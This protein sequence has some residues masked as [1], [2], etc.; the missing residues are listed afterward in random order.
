MDPSIAKTRDSIRVRALGLC[1]LAAASACGESGD[2]P[3]KSVDPRPAILFG[4]TYATSPWPRDGFRLDSLPFDG[5]PAQLSDLAATMGELDGAPI[6]TS[7]F[8]PSE[9]GSLPT[10]PIAGK[11]LLVDLTD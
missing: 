6:R 2:S 7:I 10:G 9:G 11:A 1:L 4:S 8:F 3:T 5:N